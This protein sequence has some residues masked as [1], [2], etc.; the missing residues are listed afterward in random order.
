VRAAVA[1]V[2]LALFASVSSGASLS[3]NWESEVMELGEGHVDASLETSP[4]ESERV[5]LLQESM[6]AEQQME[7]FPA[8]A[9]GNSS[10]STGKGSGSGSGYDKAKALRQAKVR[11]YISKIKTFQKIKKQKWDP[12]TEQQLA[13]KLVMVDDLMKTTKQDR[14]IEN[15]LR[16][17][18]PKGYNVELSL[19]RYAEGKSERV[20]E[21]KAVE[22][23]EKLEAKR[24]KERNQA[25]EKEQKDIKVQITKYEKHVP[26]KL[27]KKWN[28]AKKQSDNAMK[29]E[30]AKKATP[31][32]KAFSKEYALHKNVEKERDYP[33]EGA[34]PSKTAAAAAKPAVAAPA[35]AKVAPA[36]APAKPAAT[37]GES[38]AKDAEAMAEVD[39]VLRQANDWHPDE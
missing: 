7:G 4:E 3:A 8:A 23:R 6:L 11:A 37:L 1:L 17:G 38:P 39:D 5:V 25:R 14:D 34:V 24:K 12:E 32:M 26:K 9:A 15:K 10:N 20:K 33:Q 30:T 31:E 13:E 16:K 35:P 28:K 2:A 27:M 19:T 29:E 21:K 36:A 22:K 18:A